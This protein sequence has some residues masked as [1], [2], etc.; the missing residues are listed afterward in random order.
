MNDLEEAATKVK[1]GPEK[2]R[3]QTEEDRKMTAYHE[4]GHALVSWH[5]P[6]MDPVHR[7]S[8]VSRGLSLGHTMME[9]TERV[10]ETKTRLLE[11]IAV[12]L[13]GRAAENLV[14]KEMT[15][16]ASDDIAKASEVAREMVVEFGMSDLGPVNL[17][18]DPRSPY[19]ASELSPE[20]AGKIDEQIKQITDVGYKNA[21]EILSKLRKKL[22][23]LA[24]EL[25]KRETIESEEFSKL[26]GPKKALAIVKV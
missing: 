23:V 22:D 16:G 5:M 24:E 4:A 12:M 21:S 3:L 6:H 9:P 25:M 11:E 1:L 15:T 18:P 17:R 14:F 10:H 20:M 26:M 19:E 13:G 8:I 2:R 7:I